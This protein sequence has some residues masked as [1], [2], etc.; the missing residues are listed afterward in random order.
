MDRDPYQ[1]H[2]RYTHCQ[3]T[4]IKPGSAQKAGYSYPCQCGLFEP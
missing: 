3:A 4:I 1:L 2:V